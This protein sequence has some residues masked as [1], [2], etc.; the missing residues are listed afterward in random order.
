MAAHTS[1]V[2]TVAAVALIAIASVALAACGDSVAP[3][4]SEPATGEAT[5]DRHVPLEGQ[6]NFRDLGGYSTMDG[7]RVKWGQVYRS[8][9]LGQLT[10]GDV[11]ALEALELRTVV[12]FLLPEEIDQHGPDRLPAGTRDGPTS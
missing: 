2:H 10:D 8:G 5:R 3:T 11:A 7:R 4:T 12:N 1:G 6:S 9:E